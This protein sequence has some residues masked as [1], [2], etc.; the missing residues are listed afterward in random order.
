MLNIKAQ[1]HGL[2]M[3]EVLVSL[4]LLGVGLLGALSLQA[5]SLNTS[6]RANFTLEAQLAAMD[7]T[8]RLLAY[9]NT[10][11][12]AADIDDYDG[13][14]TSQ[15]YVDPNCNPCDRVQTIAFDRFSWKQLL[16]GN[17]AGNEISLPSAQ[18]E[19]NWDDANNTYTIIVRYD[20]D[21][22]GANGTDCDPNDTGD[23][24]CFIMEV[25]L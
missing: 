6:Q 8:S 16:E 17:A 18:G 5:T 23:L 3:V 24:T 13:T 9:G 25:R 10:Q 21:R 15:V 2:G 4:L 12:T 19:V 7:M 14:D 11:P 1:Q 20:R 22:T